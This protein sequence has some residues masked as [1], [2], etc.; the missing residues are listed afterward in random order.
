MAPPPAVGGAPGRAP[1]T[2]FLKMPYNLLVIVIIIIGIFVVIVIV[3]VIVSI[4][5]VII[6]I[7]IIVIK[8]AS[9]ANRH[10]RLLKPSPARSPKRLDG[11]QHF[12]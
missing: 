6:I 10:A 8:R 1:P 5:L 12:A 9:D 11:N 7:I 4:I 3:I 2:R